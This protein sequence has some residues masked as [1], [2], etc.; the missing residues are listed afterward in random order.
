MPVELALAGCRWPWRMEG[1]RTAE[2][3][4]SRGP[5]LSGGGVL[6]IQVPADLAPVLAYVSGRGWA[7][8]AGRGLLRI[9]LLPLAG[10]DFEGALTKWL[11]CKFRGRLGLAEYLNSDLL[12]RP[13]LFVV[14]AS[15][16]TTSSAIVDDVQD[17]VDLAKKLSPDATCSFVILHGRAH[18]PSSGTTVFDCGWPEGLAGACFTAPIDSAW[19]AY[20]HLR[21]AWESGG[22]VDTAVRCAEAIAGS[23]SRSQDDEA[24][25]AALNKFASQEFAALPGLARDAWLDRV[26]NHG[27]SEAEGVLEEAEPNMVGGFAPQPWIARALLIESQVPS[28]LARRVRRDLVCRPLVEQLL[29]VCF[30]IESRLQAYGAPLPGSS[31]PEDALKWYERYLRGPDASMVARLYPKSH[32]CRPSNPWDFASMGAFI[33]G[34]HGKREPAYDAKHLR[35]ALAH[36]HYIGWSGV[37]LGRTLRGIGMGGWSQRMSGK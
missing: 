33:H 18:P 28:H 37:L 7:Q 12:V 4:F 23:A 25:E 15:E 14:D 35:N 13:I 1:E 17:F 19:K 6:P 16:V 32:P 36:G 5:W 24:I 27:A 34:N 31:P 30:S 29:M 20:L 9:E 2:D 10:R 22:Q 21:A 11:G 26:A 8:D 3:W